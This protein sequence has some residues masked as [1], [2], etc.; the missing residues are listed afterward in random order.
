MKTKNK[1][2]RGI[3]AAVC[4]ATLFFLTSC[5]SSGVDSA[6]ANQVLTNSNSHQQYALYL[7]EDGRITVNKTL[8]FLP[9]RISHLRIS[10]RN[11]KSN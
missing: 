8:T 3:F 6:A 7:F 9:I 11:K 4:F 2:G 1:L 10:R 5:S